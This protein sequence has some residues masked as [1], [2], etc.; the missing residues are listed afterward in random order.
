MSVNSRTLVSPSTARLTGT[1]PT[2]YAL[3]R[4]RIAAELPALD[5]AERAALA[6][7]LTHDKKRA[8]GE[9]PWVL[10]VCAGEVVI[11]PVPASTVDALLAEELA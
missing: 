9:Q 7:A 2:R 1:L 4:Y 3:R 10:P 8:G 11:A 6:G 5:A